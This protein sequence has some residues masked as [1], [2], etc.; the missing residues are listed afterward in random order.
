[1]APRTLRSMLNETLNHE[2]TSCVHLC[3]S[4]GIRSGS[5]EGQGLESLPVPCRQHFCV[6]FPTAR[7]VAS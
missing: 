1:M 3:I 2:M 7:V 6:W 4:Q 5:Q